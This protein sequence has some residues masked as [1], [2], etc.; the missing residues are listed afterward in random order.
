VKFI[1][2]KLIPVLIFSLACC[3]FASAQ[4]SPSLSNGK[5]EFTAFGGA[6]FGNKFQFPTLVFANGAVG[7]QNVGMRYASGYQI[8][9]RGTENLGDHAA[10]YLEYNFANQPLLFTNLSPTVQSLS[11]GHNVNRLTYDGSYLFLPPSKRF[12]PYVKAGA[13]TAL[14]Y[15]N[16]HS[17]EDARALGV[18][19]RDSWEFDFNWG[20]GLNTR[21]DDQAAL[22]FEFKNQ[23]SGFPSYG[24]PRNA[25]I[26][27]SQFVPG[28][29]RDGFLHNWQ[30]NIGVTYIWDDD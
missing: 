1:V 17:K 10:V 28:V 6:S 15:I 25:Q 2:S 7:S 8:G 12:R 18:N 21:V 23:I 9:I 24:L 20:A 13:G 3:P 26:Q 19:L 29:S 16:G 4:V 14:F 11:L 5:F 27:G 30:I 22:S